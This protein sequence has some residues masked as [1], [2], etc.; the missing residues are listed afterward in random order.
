MRHID[1]QK[2]YTLQGDRKG[3]FGT[4]HGYEVGVVTDMR[5]DTVYAV[6]NYLFAAPLTLEQQASFLGSM[7]AVYANASFQMDGKAVSIDLP[8]G[9]ATKKKLERADAVL[10]AAAAAFT[11]LGVSQHEGCALCE[12]EGY[13]RVRL[14]RGFYM[15]THDSCYDKLMDQVK[16]HY[17]QVDASTQNLGKGYLFAVCGALLGALVNFLAYYYGGYQVA[18]LY[19]L[20]PAGAMFMYKAAKAPLRKEIPF[21]LAGMS[22]VI[23]VGLIF[24][25]YNLFAVSWGMSL[26]EFITEGI[27]DVDV[28]TLFVSDLVTALLFSV[29]GIL[30]V[31]RYLFKPRT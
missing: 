4:I 31:W 3:A 30:I 13:D 19:A 18:L 12:G 27:P 17:R 20:V 7:K 6:V 5:F 10:R 1:I 15:K 21:V 24:F 28:L 29:F 23:S 8:G 14:I 22:V 25:I 9:L 26:M 2:K 16:E 11:A